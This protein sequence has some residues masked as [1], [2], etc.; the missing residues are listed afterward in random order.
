MEAQP[1]I[2]MLQKRSKCVSGVSIG[3]CAIADWLAEDFRSV[4]RQ[5]NDWSVS[6]FNSVG[7]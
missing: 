5:Q 4:T 1:V 3:G 6:A 7:Q 2:C